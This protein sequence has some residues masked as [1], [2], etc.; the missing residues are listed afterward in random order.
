[1][2]NRVLQTKS[3]MVNKILQAPKPNTKKQLRSF[4]GLIG[5]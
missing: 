4:L 2:G 3:E 5:Y 1:V